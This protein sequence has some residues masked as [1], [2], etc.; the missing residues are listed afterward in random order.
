MSSAFSSAAA[1]ASIPVGRPT[2]WMFLAI[3]ASPSSSNH[4]RPLR[5]SKMSQLLRRCPARHQTTTTQERERFRAVAKVSSAARMRNLMFVSFAL[6][7]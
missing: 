4:A 6:P 2:N 1:A 7:S 3:G 5:L